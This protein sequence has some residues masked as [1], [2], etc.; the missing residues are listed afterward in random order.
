MQIFPGDAVSKLAKHILN[1]LE[2][3]VLGRASCCARSRRNVV[4]TSV[5]TVGTSGSAVFA[6][7]PLETFG[8]K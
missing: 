1:D 7:A 3:P 2:I 6:A 8:A 4:A 5:A